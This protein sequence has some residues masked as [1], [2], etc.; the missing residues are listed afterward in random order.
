MAVKSKTPAITKAL[1]DELAEVRAQLRS[2]TAREKHLKAMFKTAGAGVY[3]GAH[4][5]VE[6]TFT[7]RPQ[8][9]MDAVRVAVG[10]DFM[11]ANSYQVSVM[12][13]NAVE[14]A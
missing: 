2:F 3:K 4:Y 12:N 5:T 10:E 6:I 11:V 8:I 7:E 9:N 14:V 13:I 1:V